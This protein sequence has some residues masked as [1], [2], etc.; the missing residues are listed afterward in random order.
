MTEMP[1]PDWNDVLQKIKAYF[2]PVA[3]V[4]AMKLDV[5]TPLGEGPKSAQVL[6][7]SL[8]V[9]ARRL[10][11]LLYSLANTGLITREGDRFENSTLA[12]EFL[13]RGRPRYMGGSHELYS[14]IF[15]ATLSTAESVRTGRPAALHDWEHMPEEQLRAVLR[16]LNP[17]AA[18]SGRFLVERHDFGR[19]KRVLDIGGGGGGMAIGLCQACPGLEAKIVELPRIAPIANDLVAAS[20]LTSR[21][22][23]V[24]HDITQAPLAELHD[25]AVLRSFFQVLPPDA[26]R[27][28]AANVGR[29][30][31][32]GGE[33]FII[34]LVLDD[35]RGGPAGALGMNLFFLNAYAD[36]EAYTESEYREW[37][38]AA[39][40]T[41]ITR[42]PFAGFDNSLI[43]ARKNA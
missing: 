12:N 3:I 36:G 14:D 10:R 26:A 16:G 31:R 33:V 17:G 39:G 19:F 40:F 13:V 30:I 34:G 28:A 9:P 5:F 20:G 4:S 29:S 32:P 2:N 1:R 7:D 27:H 42:A 24:S 18:A 11:M 25:A 38:E 8:G 22:R 43:T 23:A 21:I 15:A 35:D 6:A 41:H 37:L